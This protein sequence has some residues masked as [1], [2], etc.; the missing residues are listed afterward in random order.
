MYYFAIKLTGHEQQVGAERL[1]RSAMVHTE[2]QDSGLNIPHR[3]Q[4]M[5]MPGQSPEERLQVLRA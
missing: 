2:P 4:A 3:E 1:T 5:L